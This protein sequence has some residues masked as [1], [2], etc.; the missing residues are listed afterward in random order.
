VSTHERFDRIEIVTSSDRSFGIVMACALLVVSL[1]N[2]W[3]N[4]RLWPWTAG[5]AALFLT[6]ALINP[7]KLNPLN[8]GWLKFGHLLHKI[9]SP[10]VMAIL[11]Y[12]AVLPTALAVRAIGKDLLRLKRQSAAE[13]Y[14][15][16]RDLP[17]PN[18][19]R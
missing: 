17:A 3:H 1:L 13:S 14:W 12:G 2:G 4:G 5:L 8:R 11:F 19:I 18:L 7:A 16:I 10:I 15:I 9:V 6:I